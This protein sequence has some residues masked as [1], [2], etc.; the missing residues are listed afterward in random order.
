MKKLS[1]QAEI[2]EALITP[3]MPALYKTAYRL[4]GGRE[5][6]E[7]L[8]Q[9]ILTKL[10]PQTA[11]MQTVEMLGPWLKKVLYR[12]F[13]DEVRKHSRRPESRL[14]GTEDELSALKS[15]A[16][17]PEEMAELSEIRENLQAALNTLEK[18]DRL[19]LVMHLVEGYTFAEMAEI[20][21]TPSE[22]LKTQ[23]RRAKVKV[24]KYLKI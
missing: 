15:P 12:H 4:T 7:D 16:A 2:F 13:V 20:F 5:A 10:Y 6:S 14:S 1:T 23:V 3:H 21:N 19:I 24:K 9:A 11:D 8:V 18:H 17:N 22:T